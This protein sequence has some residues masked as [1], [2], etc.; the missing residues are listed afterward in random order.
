MFTKA[1]YS[2]LLFLFLLTSSCAKDEVTFKTAQKQTPPISKE[3]P[4]EQL[5]PEKEISDSA[6]STPSQTSQVNIIEPRPTPKVRRVVRRAYTVND[7]ASEKGTT[8]PLKKPPLK[9]ASVSTASK[10]SPHSETTRPRKVILPLSKEVVGTPEAET[11]EEVSSSSTR[12]K[13]DIPDPVY[14]ITE[15]ISPSPTPDKRDIPDIV[16]EITED[17]S[18]SP[19]RDKRDIPD[20]LYEITEDIFP[21][22]TRDERDLPDS[23]HEITENIF[24][25]PTRDERDLP[26]TIILPLEDIIISVAENFTETFTPPKKKL[27]KIE[28][29]IIADNSK[30]LKPHVDKGMEPNIKKLLSPLDQ[31]DWQLG[32]LNTD[33]LAGSGKPGFSGELSVFGSSDGQTLRFL[34]KGDYSLDTASRMLISKI[35]EQDHRG[36]ILSHVT[37]SPLYSDYTF[38]TSDGVIQSA[39]KNGQISSSYEQPLKVLLQSVE[40]RESVN[41]NFYRENSE[42]IV[43]MMTDEDEMSDGGPFATTA[44]EVAKTLHKTWPKKKISVYGIIADQTCMDK[45]NSKEI[46]GDELHV[47]E[48]AVI[49][50]QIIELTKLEKT[51]GSIMSLC[52]NYGEGLSLLGKHAQQKVKSYEKELQNIPLNGSTALT[53]SSGVEKNWTLE[54]KKLRITDTLEEGETVTIRYKIPVTKRITPEQ[55]KNEDF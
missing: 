52:S 39:L 44:N 24:P 55:W 23:V 16:Y 10:R 13:R 9:T 27:K 31:F 40:K 43:F 32:H 1:I 37:N 8:Q 53:F 54:G 30:S 36:I 50:R 47:S 51:K 19:A 42:L 22:S 14:K 21:S 15:E 12:D 34:K 25:S 4:E 41:T 2:L 17:I 49:G 46:T 35:K 45:R 3:E 33:A 29:V 48:N 6:V 11:L 38:S 28:I 18:P 20:P 5:T 7:P 26:K